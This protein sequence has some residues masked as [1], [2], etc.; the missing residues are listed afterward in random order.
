MKHSDA[1]H[2][3]HF[4]NLLNR[5]ETLID[6][7]N[8]AEINM[9]HWRYEITQQTQTQQKSLQHLQEEL[10]R[11]EHMMTQAHLENASMAADTPNPQ[12]DAFLDG[13][14]NTEQ[15]L[16]RQ[17]HGHRAEITRITQHAITQINQTTSHAIS[18]IEEKLS[19]FTPPS[20]HQIKPMLHETLF[21]SLNTPNETESNV[22]D[23][24]SSS[25]RTWRSIS[26]ALLTT[27]VSVF[28]FS[29][30]AN[31]EYPWEMRQQA[32]NERDAGRVLLNAWPSLTLEEK[33][34]ILYRAS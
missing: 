1:K 34:K 9:N 7:F 31:G 18:S 2:F 17:I 26:V 23:R 29:I 25:K 8:R 12:E 10:V 32:M 30:Y 11:L 5:T 3:S 13:L 15:Q 20:I 24:V 16:L 14:K 33:N 6:L 4:H 21:E 27:V 28:I 19:T 22:H